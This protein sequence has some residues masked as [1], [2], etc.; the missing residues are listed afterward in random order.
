MKN[1][2]DLNCSQRV[3]DL[4][5]QML[6]KPRFLSLQQS[7]IIT[8]IYQQ[9][10]EKSIALK[11]AL[12]FKRVCELIEIDI[13]P[14]ELIVGN[15]EKG[16]R[17]GIV[18]VESGIA[19]LKD[20][21]REI[22][23]RPQDRFAVN[24]QDIDE[25]Y[26]T[27]VPFWQGKS[28]EDIIE[29]E[30][31][32][33]NKKIGKVVKI[34]QTDHA[35]GHINP[36]NQTWLEQGPLALSLQAAKLYQETGKE[37]YYCV[38]LV[39]Q[40]AVTFIKRYGQLAEELMA[41]SVDPDMKDNYLLIANNCRILA[42]KPA[43]DFHQ[44]VQ[45]IWFLYTLLHLESNASSFSPGRLD[46]VLY[47]YYK[48]SDIN[49]VQAL[50]LIECLWLKF[51]Q[52]V[53][54]RSKASARYFAGFPIG[55]NLCVGGYDRK[56]ED[57]V[58]DLSYLMLKASEHLGLPQPNLSARINKNTSWEFL[59][60]CT[61]VIGKGSGMP[62][63]FND[64]SIMPALLNN[65]I[66]KSDAYDYSVVG[67]VELTTNGNYLGWSDAAMFNIVKAL[68]LTLNNG[69]CLLTD[70]Q[71]GLDLG[72]LTD[73]ST[74]EDLKSAL[75]KQVAYFVDQMID[76][77]DYVDRLHGDILPSAFLSGVLD[78]CLVKGIDV[79]KG[80]A[81]YNLSGI[82]LIQVA[83]LAD[84]LA[85]INQLVYQQKIINPAYLLANLKD[86]FSDEIL[87]QRLLNKVEKYGNDVDW[88]D[89][90]A[91]EFV[92]D[93]A[94]LLTKYTNARGGI[95]QTG[96]YTVSAHVPMGKNVGATADGR[97]A[98]EPL[99]DGGM[100]A[101]YG[102]DIAGPTALLNSVNKI[103]S[104]VAGNGTLLNMKFVPSLFA[105]NEGRDKFTQLLQS[106]ANLKIHHVQFNVVN[107]DDLIKAQQNPE[108][109]RNMTIR[110]AGYTAYFTELSSDLQDEI[111]ARNSYGE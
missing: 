103:Q 50:E 25:F 36:N 75:K 78:D 87:R 94:Q 4:K 105:T 59:Q 26:Q 111:I 8:E 45:S 63:I 44:A 108:Q 24:E 37:F 7:K 91:N 10:P 81:K 15:R 23:T 38:E 80:G 49:E 51:N 93:F 46:Q 52:I 102:R 86:N 73:Y 100:S 2:D 98:G 83:N 17:S 106:F 55:F 66:S 41:E 27:L 32:A 29:K 56:G 57:S 58:N 21:I 12:A 68:E 64:D 16:V 30:I 1:L 6:D 97:K 42:E 77:C 9:Y 18:F 95:Y 14:R 62:Q 92:Q 20:E 11:R 82:Q 40:G 74:F 107:K 19:W 33:I 99:A 65:G 48:E 101:V 88:I 69:R 39:N 53:Y 34:N 76:C 70:E 72:N 13:N 85:A 35:Q 3:K 79:T 54:M 84:S 22:P 110:V 31:G 109:Y 28:L 104:N 90:L 89:N 61:N 71:I 96:L 60:M 67:C 47:P 43:E 5:Q